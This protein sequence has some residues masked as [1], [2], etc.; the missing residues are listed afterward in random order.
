M[1]DDLLGRATQA[2][3]ET[4]AEPELRSGLTRARILRSAEARAGAGRGPWLRWVLALVGVLAAGSAFARLAQHWPE[5]RRV[6]SGDHGSQLVQPPARGAHSAAGT[7]AAGSQPSAAP[8]VLQTAAGAAAPSPLTAAE[9][10]EGVPTLEDEL[11]L[12]RRARR[13][14]V[15]RDPAALGAWDDYLRVAPHGRHAPEARYSHAECL[16][17]ASRI[18]EARAELEP[19]ARGEYR[20]FRQREAQALLNSEDL[21]K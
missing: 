15:A 12:F 21:G 20:G 7:A 8:A 5:V 11:Q 18:V 1:S 4:S 3:R 16:V 17:R 19:F 2:L 9:Q 6:F 14:H 10:L 13:L